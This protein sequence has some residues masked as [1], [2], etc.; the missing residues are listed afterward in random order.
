MG[1]SS[2]VYRL[3]DDTIIK[4]Y[5]ERVPLYKITREID[6][7]KKAFLAGIPT[8]ISYDIVRC[9]ENY[10]VVFEMIANAL[11]VGEAL[12]ADEFVML[13]KMI[14]A[15]PDRNTFVH[16]DFH[17]GN[18]LYQDGEI[19]VIDMAD[20]GYAHPIFDFAAGAF[21]VMLR[22]DKMVH[23][24]LNLSAENILKF[25]NALLK[26]YFQTESSKV[27][28]ELNEV[29]KAFAHLRNALFPMKHVQIPEE[30]KL[31]YIAQARK[32][33]FPNI[34]WAIRQAEHLHDMN[35]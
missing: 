32:I 14:D 33:F 12:T 24:P 23:I 2:K 35:F 25:W 15:V 34:D 29:F 6:L 20:F 7:A 26:N 28:D 9:G 16:C 1:R 19:V 31:N 10:G 11:T 18:T 13:E 17:A 8:V 30:T 4:V 27:L 22:E 3:D 21:H 5:K